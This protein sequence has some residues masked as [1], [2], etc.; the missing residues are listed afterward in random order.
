[1]PNWVTN[2][3]RFKSRGKEILNKI[4]TKTNEDKL[5]FDSNDI[6][7]DFEKILPM[8]KT[9]NITSGGNQ[10]I[11]I[12]YA[13]SKMSD[14]EKSKIINILKSK[15]SKC[16][17]YENYYNKFY[18]RKYT[19][20]ELENENKKFIDYINNGEKKYDEVKYNELGVKNL[21]DYGNIYINNVIKYG[22][23][24]WYN[25]SVDNWGTKWNSCSTYIINDNE[26]EFDTAWSCPMEVLKELSRQFKGVEIYVEYADEDIG[27]N[28]G[29]FTLLNGKVIDYCNKEGDCDF[30]MNIKGY[31]DE[32][33]EEFYNN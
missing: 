4:I 18:S 9:L 21:A 30:A 14:E 17:I 5:E 15:S 8:P 28:C 3:V 25:W 7:F 11:A 6:V 23:D 12:Q 16:D 19:D 33:I 27:S 20:E 1:M 31:T 26:V 24:T 13:I 32:D 22:Y 2:R 10:K 29:T